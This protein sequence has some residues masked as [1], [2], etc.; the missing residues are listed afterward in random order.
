MG[1]RSGGGP[2]VCQG[3][4]HRW[5]DGRG[6]RADIL[7]N[8]GQ[9]GRPWDT[10]WELATGAIQGVGGTE[11]RAGAGAAKAGVGEGRETGERGGGGGVGR[12]VGAS[13]SRRMCRSGLRS[14]LRSGGRGGAGILGLVLE[15]ALRMLRWL[16]FAVGLSGLESREGG[17]QKVGSAGVSGK[18]W[19]EVK[20]PEKVRSG[21]DERGREGSSRKRTG[22]HSLQAQLKRTD[23]KCFKCLP[24]LACALC[25]KRPESTLNTPLRSCLKL[26]PPALSFQI[27]TSTLL[28]STYSSRCAAHSDSLVVRFSVP[29]GPEN[30]YNPEGCRLT[31]WN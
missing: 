8:A 24:L 28:S 26:P 7:G 30:K 29:G 9:V 16:V 3:W 17:R 25:E 22:C 27:E 18:E 10:T 5:A 4:V 13:H 23:A 15:K 11:E 19:R 1:S 6:T 31:S 21:A 12:G 14:A 20:E 2:S